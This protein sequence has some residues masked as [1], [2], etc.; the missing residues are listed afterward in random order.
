MGA[1]TMGNRVDLNTRVARSEEVL[2]SEVDGEVVMMSI[3]QGTYSGLDG[4]GSEIWRLL[5]SP[6]KVSEI[7]DRMVARY[8]V[9]KDVCEKDVLA[10]LNDLAS[11][12][13]TQV[14][15]EPR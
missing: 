12:H 10:F 1:M 2:T 3:E 8:D 15:E 6:L 4:I 5:E 14:V 11:D 9:E 7:C 13:T